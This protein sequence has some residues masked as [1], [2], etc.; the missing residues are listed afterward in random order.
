MRSLYFIIACLALLFFISCQKEIDDAGGSSVSANFKAKIDG[1]WWV[2]DKIA[3]ANKAFGFITLNGQS[4]DKRSLRIILID[5]GVHQYTLDQ[6]SL[7]SAF[8]I[9]SNLTN[10]AAFTTTDA[11]IDGQVRITAIDTA[12]KTMSGT[13]SFLTARQSDTIQRNFTEGSFTNIPYSTSLTPPGSPADTFRVKINGT[14]WT[15]PTVLSVSTG[16]QIVITGS[17]AAVPKSVALTFPS[18]ITPGAYPFSFTTGTH[19]GVYTPDADPN[20]IKFSTIG[21]LIILEHNAGTKR[22][23]GNFNFTAN[24]LLNPLNFALLTEGYFSVTYN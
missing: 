4:N 10:I 11:T 23:R 13:F 20:H 2:A 7:N 21:T 18:G 22:I 8:Y 12:N 14:L 19:I 15:P 17:D 16:T 24:E 9:D 3:Y 6:G 5:S 1:S